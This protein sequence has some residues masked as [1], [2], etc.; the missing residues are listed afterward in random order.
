MTIIVY[1]PASKACYADRMHSLSGSLKPVYVEATKVLSTV[2]GH[3]FAATGADSLYCLGQLIDHCIEAFTKGEVLPLGS[4][5]HTECSVIV[6]G[7]DYDDV[8]I[9]QPYGEGLILTPAS[10]WDIYKFPWARGAGGT[11]YDAYYCEHRD[12]VKAL[13]LTCEHAFGCGFGY[14]KF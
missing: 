13:E 2:A 1:D 5:K 11:F 9:S 8:F 12:A 14:D 4:I 6:R 10:D 7:K 3:K